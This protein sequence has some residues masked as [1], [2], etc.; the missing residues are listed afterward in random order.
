MSGATPERTRWGWTTS[1]P[2]P[3]PGPRR[4]PRTLVRRVG[5]EYRPRLSVTT[6]GRVGSGR[7]RRKSGPGISPDASPGRFGSASNVDGGADLEPRGRFHVLGSAGVERERPT[8]GS[9]IVRRGLLPGSIRR[10][11]ARDVG[12]DGI[13]VESESAVDVAPHRSRDESR[14]SGR[15]RRAQLHLVDAR[16]PAGRRRRCLV[17]HV[18]RR[19]DARRAVGLGDAE[20]D[21]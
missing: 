15:G 12:P 4:R 14:Q 20:G 18:R 6:S 7:K 19:R 21:G 2:H 11:D 3:R 10:R 5:G 8:R 9:R 17:R 16:R 13:A 1:R